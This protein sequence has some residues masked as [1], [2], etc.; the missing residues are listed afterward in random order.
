MPTFKV[1]KTTGEEQAKAIQDFWD[2]SKPWVMKKLK[3][4]TWCASPDCVIKC[5]RHIT[6][7]K[8]EPHELVSIADFSGVCREYI[9]KVLDEVKDG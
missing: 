3:D 2:K 5:E 7:C 9:R 6:R 1:D 4:I 8:V